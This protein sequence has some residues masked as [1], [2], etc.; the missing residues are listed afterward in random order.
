MSRKALNKRF[1]LRG[2]MGREALD[3]RLD[4]RGQMSQRSNETEVKWG[5]A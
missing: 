4:L 2:Q 3:K 5:A 1:D